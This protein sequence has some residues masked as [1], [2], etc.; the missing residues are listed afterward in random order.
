MN[1]DAFGKRH[2]L[3]AHVSP[4]FARYPPEMT[5]ADVVM[6]VMS[7]LRG[8]FG[9]VPE[10]LETIVTRWHEDP[11]SCGAYSFRQVHRTLAFRVLM[12]K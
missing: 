9:D 1:M 11:F 8:M 5:D 7:T 6:E 10:A 4:P 3:V 2:L 12:V